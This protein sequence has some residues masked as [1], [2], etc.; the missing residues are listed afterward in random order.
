M[1]IRD[2]YNYPSLNRKDLMYLSTIN[3]QRDEQKTTT[4]KFITD[5]NI[6]YNLYNLDI[7]GIFLP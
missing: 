2:P 1:E 4:K 5:R 3:Q 7:N 6:S